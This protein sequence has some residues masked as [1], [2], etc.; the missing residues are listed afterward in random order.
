MRSAAA[1]ATYSA[2]AVVEQYAAQP[3]RSAGPV[4]RS[5]D[6]PSASDGLRGVDGEGAD[7]AAAAA[8]ATAADTTAATAAAAAATTCAASGFGE[9]EAVPADWEPPEEDLA[10][11]VDAVCLGMDHLARPTSASQ[12]TKRKREDGSTKGGNEQAASSEAR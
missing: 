7:D 5:F 11:L 8:A 2:V 12:R 9:D 1:S 4:S 10:M 6:G 3:D